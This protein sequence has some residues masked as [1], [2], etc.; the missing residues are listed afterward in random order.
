MRLRHVPLET[1]AEAQ[2]RAK[3][4]LPKSVYVA[5]MA[6]VEKGATL[7]RNVAVFDDVGFSP[8]VG[9]TA[10]P[11]RD[12]GTTVLGERLAMPVIIAPAG[13]QAVWPDGDVAVAR[14]AASMGTAMSASNFAGSPLVR[15]VEANPAT[16]F[17]LYWSGDRDDIA[18]R[19]EHARA[20]G[21]KA[22]IITLDATAYASR[23]WGSPTF[24]ERLDLPSALR[25]SPVGL[26]RPR[27]LLRFLCNG[28]FP[29]LKVPNLATT[30]DGIPTMFE[31]VRRWAMT[32]RPTW[33]D[34][35]WLR[36]LWSGP[37]LVKG[38]F[39]PDDARRAVDVGASAISV[40]NHGGNNLDTTPA[41]LRA[42]PA[43]AQAVGGEVEVLFDGGVRR[44]GDV[45]KALA[46][47]ARAVLVG[48]PWIF[49]L[50]ADGE[51][52]VREVLE[53][54]RAGLDDTLVRLGHDSIADLSPHDLVLPRD[55]ALS[56]SSNPASAVAHGGAQAT[57]RR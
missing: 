36:A 26:S 45:A 6:A 30:A 13:V 2:R 29:D 37:F 57:A 25:F 22:L 7:D 24:P 56:L 42:L 46:L 19:V 35:A 23:D 10:A 48:R 51:R 31:G 43:I 5:I 9:M 11:A 28:G 33:D 34:V 14:A 12:L 18:G 38:V 16:F 8:R 27:W 17:Q 32:P 54:L 49:G 4:R 15:I 3:R 39:H 40:S 41:A 55:F 44:G 21:V 47:G 53:I 50:A 20:I 52:G 1:V